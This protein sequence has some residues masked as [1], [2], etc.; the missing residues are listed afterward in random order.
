MNEALPVFVVVGHA[1]RGKSSIVATLSSDETIEIARDPGTTTKTQAYPLRVR[2]ETLYTLVD[3]PGFER[4]RQALAWM[5]EHETTTQ[6]RSQVVARFV[7]AHRDDPRM[8]SECELL[9]PI[10]AGGAILYVVD[11]SAPFTPAY[12]AETEILRWTGRP[13]M[14]LINPIRGEPY[15]DEWRA[16]L[17]QYFSLVRVFNAHHA[18]LPRRIALLATLREL[19]DA[20]RAPLD[21][22]IDALLADRDARLSEAA[23]AI[24]D[25]LVDLLSAREEVRLPEHGETEAEREALSKRFF[26]RLR[27]RELRLRHD[28]RRI[29]LHSRLQVTQTE[30]FETPG[31]GLFDRSTWSRLGLSR[32]QLMATGVAAGALAGGAVD[33]AVGGTSLLLGTAVGGL[34]GLAT[35]YLGFDKLARTHVLGSPMGGLLLRIGPIQSPNF[36]W[37]VLD[38]ALLFHAAVA[39]HAHARRAPIDLAGRPSIVQGLASDERR[40]LGGL[41]E[42]ARRYA[43]QPSQIDRLRLEIGEKL[44]ALL[45]ELE[46]M[47]SGEPR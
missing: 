36:G 6:E 29:H 42:Q 41:F 8:R 34:I 18:D 47:G 17:D 35:S 1:N 40:V 12:E 21:Y 14:A 20:W 16:V 43:G 46:S 11:G 4:A 30:G 45:H 23:G 32:S 26:A 3:T 13:R 5:R 28:L 10:L 24:A 33:A 19:V 37:V 22:A 44:H 39:H 31:E 2:G 25:A 15:V 38:R 9:R 7:D 27:E